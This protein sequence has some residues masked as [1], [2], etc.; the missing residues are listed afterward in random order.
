MKKLAV[1]ALIILV[2][3]VLTV[4][5]KDYVAHLMQQRSLNT[6]GGELPDLS[7]VA[8]SFDNPADAARFHRITGLINQKN[9]E[10]ALPRVVKSGISF[11]SIA[12]Q[13]NSNM[14][15]AKFRLTDAG[16][17]AAQTAKAKHEFRQMRVSLCG[18]LTNLS[19]ENQ[20]T[21]FNQHAFFRVKFYDKDMGFLATQDRELVNCVG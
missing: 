10:L 12:M 7:P 19:S 15:E 21:L 6:S 3:A 14:I 4:L 8:L 9:Q 20:A 17:K 13:D 1:L 5:G 11:E 18:L 2:V 16:D